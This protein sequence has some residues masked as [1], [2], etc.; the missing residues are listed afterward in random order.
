M[1]RSRKFINGTVLLLVVLALLVLPFAGLS[2][3]SASAFVPKKHP[4]SPPSR[5]AGDPADYYDK[6]YQGVFPVVVYRFDKAGLITLNALMA[7]GENARVLCWA[8][9]R[10]S[11]NQVKNVEYNPLDGTVTFKLTASPSL[12]ALFP[13]E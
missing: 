13:P 10:W 7:G 4:K 2:W 9:T 11:D 8:Y 6:A 12:C 3:T 5:T 1:F